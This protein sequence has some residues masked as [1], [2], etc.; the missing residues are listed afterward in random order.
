MTALS[1][2]RNRSVILIMGGRDKDMDFRPLTDRVREKVKRLVLMGETRDKLKG[3]LAGLAPIV[4]AETMGEAVEVSR[5]A[6]LP[7]DTV[8]LSPACASFD[9]FKDYKERGD[10][11]QK[12]VLR[13]NGQEPPAE[14]REGA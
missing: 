8:L 3:V 1:N 10:V 7:G 5:E 6:A 4:F 9:M 2:F 14:V 12:E 11:F 13:V